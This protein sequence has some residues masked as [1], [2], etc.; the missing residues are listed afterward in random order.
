MDR[1]QGLS[2]AEGIASAK[3]FVFKTNKF[4]GNRT[5]ITEDKIPS[6]TEALREALAK[7]QEDIKAL[8][9]KA[10]AEG[11]SE[12]GDVFGAYVEMLSDEEL[13]FI[14]NNF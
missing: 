11:A 2:A 8:Q 7:A 6:E 4:S 3:A 14:S 5:T 12:Q 10:Y 13:V 9:E 1:L